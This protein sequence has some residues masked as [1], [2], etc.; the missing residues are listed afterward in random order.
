MLTK[1]G[2]DKQWQDQIFKYATESGTDPIAMAAMMWW[3][4]RGFPA[5]GAA[6]SNGD[7]DTNG[8]GPWQ[9]TSQSWQ[10]SDYAT[11]VY[12]PARATQVAAG[13]IASMGGK[14]ASQQLGSI[15]QDFSK[16]SSINSFATVA[17]NYN[18]GGGTYRNPGV[19]Q[20]KDPSRS[21]LQGSKGP[22]YDKKQTIID[23]YVVGA[24]Y[25]YYQIATG[26]PISKFTNNSDYASEAI[27]KEELIKGLS[28]NTVQSG[29]A[30]S[31]DSGNC[32][33]TCAG[34]PSTTSTSSGGST[35]P[36]GGAQTTI[37]L[38]PG[39]SPG[40]T[41]QT[42]TASGL[43]TIETGGA[44]GEMEDMWNTTQKIKTKLEAAGYKVVLTKNTKDE[45]ISHITRV[46][47]ADGAGAALVV[48]MH[49]DGANT[50]G[51]AKDGLGV[52]PQKVGGYRENRDDKKRK[53]FENTAAAQASQKYAAIIADERS[54][55]G[56]KTKVTDL[57]F[58]AD[59]PGL[60]ANGTMSNVQLLSNT[61]WVY[62]ET[63][64][65]GFDSEK[66][67]TGI[68]NGVMK[69]VPNGSV[70]TNAG[71]ISSTVSP[72]SGCG[73]VVGSIVQTAVN[74]SW[75]DGSHG[76]EPKPEYV[77]ALKQY[78]PI[79]GKRIGKG[80]GADCAV[81]V[82]TVM[83]ASGADPNYPDNWT[84]GQDDYVKS[85]PEKYDIATGITSVS[86]LQPG[87][88]MVVNQGPGGRHHTWIYV[89]PQGGAKNYDNASASQD[90]RTA[91]LGKT[92]IKDLSI[93]TRARLK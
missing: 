68:A 65:K 24:T 3:E 49:Y 74:L 31:V 30:G 28:T 64:K 9:I 61:P 77:A 38:D 85:H 7:S 13:M 54:A 20:Y 81:F 46:Q 47:R 84:K 25:V 70:S 29:S 33:A 14:A 17:K 59:R 5:Y 26:G 15:E 75:A 79:Q 91:N 78:N 44:P 43:K 12:D 16:G 67:A 72:A 56:D 4:H 92:G 76:L 36:T 88:I 10:G 93:Y 57:S 60:L 83:H 52:T 89:G 42:D 1:S 55:T 35:T 19:A 18:A 48:S 62:N 39:H 2:L 53:T 23:D 73:V 58:P 45:A 40:N 90:E 11:G 37:V 6:K 8:R 80:V 34:A 27:S 66:Y 63:G 69:A 50:F 82:A 87:D 22:W 86:D 51:V 71:A 32:E 41:R 21:W